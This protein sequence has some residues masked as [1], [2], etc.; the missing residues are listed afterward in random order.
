MSTAVGAQGIDLIQ[1][2]VF[3]GMDEL[4]LVDAGMINEGGSINIPWLVELSTTLGNAY[5]TGLARTANVLCEIESW[6]GMGGGGNQNWQGAGGHG[7]V[8]G[9]IITW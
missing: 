5:T 4:L 9:N 7:A 1:S 2:M 8:G 3:Q 6:E